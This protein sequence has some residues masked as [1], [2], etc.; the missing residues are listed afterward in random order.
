MIIGGVAPLAATLERLATK[1][2]AALLC[3]S[4]AQ[5]SVGGTCACRLRHPVVYPPSVAR[6]GYAK[7]GD[8]AP[9]LVRAKRR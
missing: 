7:R 2:R 8:N 6:W 9:L 4:S 5:Q 1:W 3:D